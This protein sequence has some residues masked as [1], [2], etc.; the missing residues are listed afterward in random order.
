MS[1]TSISP[2]PSALPGVCN[3]Q[4]GFDLPEGNISRP[5]CAFNWP[6]PINDLQDCC[7][8]GAQVLVFN[9]CTQYCE[10]RTGSAGWRDCVVAK[11][12]A[13]DL[14][15]NQF[16]CY[17]A[18]SISSSGVSSA[19]A[20]ATTSVQTVTQSATSTPATTGPTNV[21]E[22]EGKRHTDLAQ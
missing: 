14:N 12:P 21:P 4:V 15:V 9:N 19:S 8:Q 5:Y 2:I 10:R 22:S 16:P 11:E 17:P 7:D 6:T 18:L 1:S 20:S 13:A 3:S